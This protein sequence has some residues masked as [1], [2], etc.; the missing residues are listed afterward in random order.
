MKTSSCIYLANV[1][2]VLHLVRNG[3]L[4]DV[5]CTWYMSV[6]HILMISDPFSIAYPFPHVIYRL[7][8]GSVPEDR[9]S[10]EQVM[11]CLFV[12]FTYFGKKKRKM[13]PFFLMW[14]IHFYYLFVIQ[15]HYLFVSFF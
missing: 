14:L 2:T 11:K 3:K 10:K 5:I 8:L 12:H 1:A 6:A 13:S 15:K 9:H 7:K 4:K